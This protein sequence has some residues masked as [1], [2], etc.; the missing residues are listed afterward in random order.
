MVIALEGIDGAGKSVQLERLG[1]R[2]EHLGGAAGPRVVAVDRG[3]PIRELYLRLIASEETFPDAWTS[4]LLGAATVTDLHRASVAS[5]GSDAI[6]LFHR[7]LSSPLSDALAFGLP[8]AIVETFW[9][10]LP[11]PDLTIVIDTDPAESLRRKSAISLAEAG[12]PE[13]LD[14]RRPDAAYLAYQS[15]AR[16]G[17]LRVGE[18]AAEHGDGWATVAGDGGPDAV[19]ERIWPAVASAVGADTP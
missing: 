15:A 14:G 5:D 12:G 16:E 11:R 2:L 3:R 7:H 1:R 19:E 4:L 10:A 6:Y 17:Y 18:L 8:P 13:W 9:R